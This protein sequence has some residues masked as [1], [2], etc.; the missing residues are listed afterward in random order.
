MTE[1]ATTFFRHRARRH[2]RP[3]PGF[4]LSLGFTIAWM[5]L[6]IL[7]PLSMIAVKSA[8]LSWSEFSAVITSPRALASYGLS[9]GGALMAA[10]I[11]LVFGTLTAWVLVRY[12]FFGRRF[13]DSLIDLPFAIPTAVAGIALTAV[14]GPNGTIGKLL[15]EAG[16]QAAYTRA[17]VIIAMVFVGLPFV[18]RTLQPV[19][20]NLDPGIEEA[21]VTLGAGRLRIFCRV[22]FPAMVP[23]LATGFALS[24]ARALG[25]YGSIVF[26]SGNMPLKTEITPLLIM[27]Q[28]E[29]FNY[30]GAVSLAAVMLV[31]SFLILFAVNGLQWRQERR[32]KKIMKEVPKTALMERTL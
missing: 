24:F 21:A 2:W 6:L 23:A 14:W 27:A 12:R 32:Q 13:V 16:I 5:S 18:V 31:S 9:F 15:A 10:I 28:L 29:Q 4:G 1:S 30:K 20:E 26:I 3:L 22:L 25:E 17:G 19:L 8:S 11:N 7:I